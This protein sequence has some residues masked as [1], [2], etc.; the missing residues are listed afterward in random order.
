MKRKQDV[1]NTRVL[2]E[3]PVDIE[4]LVPCRIKLLM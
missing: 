3:D 4:L 1:L 2:T